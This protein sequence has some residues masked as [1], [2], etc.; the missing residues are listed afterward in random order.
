MMLYP[1][2]GQFVSLITVKSRKELQ[3][4]QNWQGTYL[5][6]KKLLVVLNGMNQNEKVIT[7]FYS[8]FQK[9][10]YR[11]MQ[12]CYSD[13]IIFFDPIFEDLVDDEVKLMW[14]MLCKRA[15]DLSIEFSNVQADDEYGTC[16]WVA[17]YT[18]IKTKRRVVNHIKAH[19]R[20]RDGKI[21]EHSD[22]FKLSNWC[23]QAFGL[24]GLLFGGTAWFQNKV[25]KFAQQNLYDYIVAHQNPK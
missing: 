17:S 7:N 9:R 13:K 25:R 22:Q 1:N 6:I 19:M 20:F 14:E 11:T 15:G 5:P 24:K 18:F 10:D 23:R 12:H 2:K 16:D 21:I 8:A 3:E 4:K